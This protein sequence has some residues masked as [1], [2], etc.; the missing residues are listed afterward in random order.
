M[1]KTPS[2]FRETRPPHHVSCAALACP[3]AAV[4]EYSLPDLLASLNLSANGVIL[5]RT[6]K[7]RIKCGFRA[8]KPPAVPSSAQT[9]QMLPRATSA[10]ATA[11]RLPYP[12]DPIQ[13]LRF[14]QHRAQTCDGLAIHLHSPASLA[15]KLR[16]QFRHRQ[17]QIVLAP[18]PRK[19]AAPAPTISA[20]VGARGA[21]ITM[22]SSGA[23]AA[24]KVFAATA[25]L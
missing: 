5:H 16:R 4:P 7:Y 6:A 10:G 2:R 15:P 19:S 25:I 20:A 17:M 8:A 11:G 24:T 9:P 13:V 1:C 3:I 21:N 12:L 14:H 22:S 18:P 23:N